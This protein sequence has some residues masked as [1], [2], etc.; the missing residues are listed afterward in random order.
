M[1]KKDLSAAL[2]RIPAASIRK[3]PDAAK[4]KELI[5]AVQQQARVS[6]RK[7]TRARLDRLTADAVKQVQ[8]R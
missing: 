5:S 3:A 4:R 7:V 6:T 1:F 2:R 8:T